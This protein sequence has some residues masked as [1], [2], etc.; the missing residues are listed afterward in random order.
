MYRSTS[1]AVAMEPCSDPEIPPTCVDIQ[2]AHYTP[3]TVP[4]P[5]THITPPSKMICVSTPSV[6]RSQ[7]RFQ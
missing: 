6:T 2:Q 7:S 5:I 1:Q 4:V 3:V